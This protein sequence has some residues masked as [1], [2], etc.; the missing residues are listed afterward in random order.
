MRV[1]IVD[2]D[3]D[4]RQ[5]VAL[6][7]SKQDWALAFA[8]TGAEALIAAAELR[9]ELV[10]MDILMPDMGGLEAARAMRADERLRGVTIIAITALAFETDLHQAYLAGFDAVITK[11]FGRRQL[12]DAIERHFP[13]LGEAGA[14]Q[15]PA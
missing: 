14:R 5:I 6:M 13:E 3:P 11:P 4:C 1:L 9:P 7:L 2:D 12:L 10:L 15:V 8:T